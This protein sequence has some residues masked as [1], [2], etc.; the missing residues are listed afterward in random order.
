VEV[1]SYD[2]IE[3]VLT[4]GIRMLWTAANDAETGITAVILDTSVVPVEKLHYLQFCSGLLGRLD[5][6]LYNRERLNTL[7]YK[8]PGR[9]H[10]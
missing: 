1:K 7:N 10:L 9:L 5:T 4:D 3:K 2:I 6:E 8:I